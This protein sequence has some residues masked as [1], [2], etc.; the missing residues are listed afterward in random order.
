MPAELTR[1]EKR[2]LRAYCTA[3]RHADAAAELGISVQTLKNHLGSIYRKVDR[4]KSHSA[5]YA[6]CLAKGF[7]PLADEEREPIG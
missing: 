4:H 5:L 2:T 3:E 7:D 6:L 1:A